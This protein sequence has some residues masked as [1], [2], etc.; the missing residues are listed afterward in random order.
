MMSTCAD[1]C[2]FVSK[3]TAHM[4]ILVRTVM[5]K[6]QGLYA[7]RTSMKVLDWRA[8]FTLIHFSHITCQRTGREEAVK[9]RVLGITSRVS[10]ITSH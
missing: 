1:S 9:Y 5:Q 10:F 2:R 3:E 7:G 6:Y 4:E 8:T